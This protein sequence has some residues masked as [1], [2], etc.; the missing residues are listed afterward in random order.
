MG[1]EPAHFLSMFDGA[2]V[3]LLGGVERGQQARYGGCTTRR[4]H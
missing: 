2:L 1:E 4:N 3:T